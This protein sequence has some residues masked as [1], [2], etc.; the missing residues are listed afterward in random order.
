MATNLTTTRLA[1]GS[2]R[3]ATS[4]LVAGIDRLTH[5]LGAWFDEQRRYHETLRELRRLDDREL[6]DIGIA[7]RDIPS[8]ARKSAAT[9]ARV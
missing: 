2:R 6:D 5:R 4:A 9:A 1:D 7:R 3:N 8:I